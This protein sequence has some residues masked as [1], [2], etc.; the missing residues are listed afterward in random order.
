MAQPRRIKFSNSARRTEIYRCRN[1]V[2]GATSQFE[3]DKLFT[4]TMD[5]AS[6][7]QFFTGREICVDL[8]AKRA[9]ARC[10]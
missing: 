4:R 1:C 8:Y 10:S 9:A 7:N 5:A 2:L 3:R 6:C